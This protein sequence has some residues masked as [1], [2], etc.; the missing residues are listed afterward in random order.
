MTMTVQGPDDCAPP[1]SLKE[2]EE[3]NTYKKTKL[4]LRASDRKHHSASAVAS[5]SCTSCVHSPDNHRSSG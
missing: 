5:R 3:K 2:K 1:G 4:K